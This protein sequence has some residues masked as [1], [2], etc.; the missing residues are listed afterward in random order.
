MNEFHPRSIKCIFIEFVFDKRFIA[1]END[2]EIAPVG[3]RIERAFDDL[4]R[5]V[6]A[7]HRVYNNLQHI[8]LPEKHV[9]CV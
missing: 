2:L 3:K 7:P 5:R 1:R 8:S 4:G 9:T 6:V